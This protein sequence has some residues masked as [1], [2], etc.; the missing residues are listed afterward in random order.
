MR[1]VV[2]LI[3]LLILPLV[4]LAEP[5]EITGT[6]TLTLVW[7]ESVSMDIARIGPVIGYAT[8][9]VYMDGTEGEVVVVDKPEH[10]VRPRK[11]VPWQLHVRACRTA[12]TGLTVCDGPWGEPS[13]LWVLCPLRADIDCNLT[14]GANDSIILSQDWGETVDE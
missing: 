10:Q 3:A 13:A 1:F 9:L 8:K 5:L 12:D 2:V 11:G 4:A 6:D 7:R 14:V